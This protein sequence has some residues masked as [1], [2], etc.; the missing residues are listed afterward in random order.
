MARS[1]LVFAVVFCAVVCLM[2]VGGAQPPESSPLPTTKP[3]RSASVGWPYAHWPPSGE[4][5]N[6][7]LVVGPPASELYGDYNHDEIQSLKQQFIALAQKSAERMG[8]PELK[9][10][11]AEMRRLNVIAELKMLADEPQV[12]FHGTRAEIAAMVLKAASQAELEST[13]RGLAKELEAKIPAIEP[14]E[15][16]PQPREGSS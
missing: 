14:R 13:I 8:A 10:S 3:L 4:V 1:I 6:A 9:Q 2:N 5:P 15:A 11:I 7:T 12:R 16:A